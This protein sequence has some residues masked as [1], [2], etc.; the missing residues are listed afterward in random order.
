MTHSYIQTERHAVYQMADGSTF[1]SA[2]PVKPE[3]KIGD[4][5]SETIGGEV[6]SGTVVRFVEIEHEYHRITPSRGDVGR[7]NDAIDAREGKKP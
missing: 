6:W 4:H 7:W 1:T 3:T 2:W 5:H